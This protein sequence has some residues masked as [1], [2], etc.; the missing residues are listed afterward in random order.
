MFHNSSKNPAIYYQGTSGEK[1]IFMAAPH[2]FINYYKDS[3]I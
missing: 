3:I 2:H 1:R